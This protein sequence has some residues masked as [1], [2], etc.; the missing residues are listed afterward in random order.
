M[1]LLYVKRHNVCAF[2]DTNDPK[3]AEFVPV[4]TF[5]A[6]SNIS[7]AIGHNLPVFETTIREFWETTEIV[8][9]ENVE[10]IRA[11]V[12]GQEVV[13]FEA[14]IGEVLHLN[15][16]PEAPI[17]FPNFYIKECFRRMG[18]PDEFKSGQ[19]IKNSLPA[20]WRY[21][22]HVFIHC[23]SIRNGGFDSANAM[24]ASEVLGLIKGRDYNFSGLIFRQ[25][26]HNL[27]GDVKEK[28]LMYLRFLQ[29]I[30]NH[31]HPELQQGGNVFVFDHMIVKTL[32]YMRSTNKRT[33]RA[34]ADIPLFGHVIGEEEEFIPDIDPDLEQEAEAEAEVEVEFPYVQEE[35]QP[36]DEPVLEAPF[37]KEV[38]IAIEPAVNVEA[39]ALCGGVKIVES[40]ET[41]D[42][43]IYGSDY[44]KSDSDAQTVPPTS[45]SKRPA[46]SDSD[47]ELEEPKAKKIKAGF[48]DLTSS[49]D[50][51]F[52]TP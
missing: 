37:V 5:L 51:V 42:A 15:D 46:D 48:E 21:F 27:I 19:I 36:A 1:D 43:G 17:E 31:L 11:I 34:I 26:K 4:F 16:N 9:V 50:S 39:G 7:F 45:S 8:T 41:L 49:S 35:E 14:T 23:L 20:H 38:Q 24:V 3:A 13:F 40:S 44:H 29:I 25:L 2:L 18:H 28:F 52:D 12:R 6:N 10:Y 32:S 33:N 47:Y 22:V 30:I